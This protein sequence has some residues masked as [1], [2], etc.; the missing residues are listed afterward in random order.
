M[1]SNSKIIEDIHLID[2][3]ILGGDYE[4]DLESAGGVEYSLPTGEELEFSK[5]S[6]V[7]IIIPKRPLLDPRYP[8]MSPRNLSRMEEYALKNQAYKKERGDIIT[9]EE[10]IPE[11]PTS[12]LRKNFRHKLHHLDAVGVYNIKLA[13]YYKK[14]FAKGYEFDDIANFPELDTE[15]TSVKRKEIVGPYIKEDFIPREDYVF[16]EEREKF[17]DRWGRYRVSYDNANMGSR[18]AKLLKSSEQEDKFNAY[19]ASI[20]VNLDADDPYGYQ[21]GK[22]GSG[23]ITRTK[24]RDLYYEEFYR[25]RLAKNSFLTEEDYLEQR[26]EEIKKI[27]NKAEEVFQQEIAAADCRRIELFEEGKRRAQ[28]IKDGH[29]SRDGPSPLI[30]SYEEEATVKAIT[31]IIRLESYNEPGFLKWKNKLV[32]QSP[33]SE[34]VD[35]T[36]DALNSENPGSDYNIGFLEGYDTG[37][38]EIATKIPK[39]L[40]DSIVESSGI[41]S[42][43]TNKDKL[44]ILKGEYIIEKYGKNP[45]GFYTE[46]EKNDTSSK[47]KIMPL[48]HDSWRIL[49]KEDIP[50]KHSQG[51]TTWRA[52]RFFGRVD[53]SK[54]ERMGEEDNPFS[55]ELPLKKKITRIDP[56]R[57]KKWSL[58]KKEKSALIFN[59]KTKRVFFRLTK[60][61][62]N[63]MKKFVRQNLLPVFLK[64]NNFLDCNLRKMSIE[65]INSGID[66]RELLINF[67]KKK[68]STKIHTRR[69]SDPLIRKAYAQTVPHSFKKSNSENAYCQDIKLDLDY[70]LPYLRSPISAPHGELNMKIK[71]ATIVYIKNFK[72]GILCPKTKKKG[73]LLQA[74]VK[75]SRAHDLNVLGITLERVSGISCVRIAHLPIKRKIFSLG[76]SPHA[77][78]KTFEQYERK[79][80]KWQFSIYAVGTK[81]RKRKKIR[82]RYIAPRTAYDIRKILKFCVFKVIPGQISFILNPKRE[83]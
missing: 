75:S 4:R 6:S 29:H 43:I 60:T 12:P 67:Q 7:D 37:F 48:I 38:Q 45:Y 23:P 78:G 26:V 44:F 25:R 22:D 16:P 58:I 21:K 46:P 71:P 27:E 81:E 65:S 18:R 49:Q 47:L 54:P 9:N 42:R 76:R 68:S 53:K 79:T 20:G 30:L 57:L 69:H 55:P 31:R 39:E 80:H 82:V 5:N 33:F 13:D 70:G 15:F 51:C 14:I 56:R 17:K 61:I 3:Y 52:Y 73:N 72:K 1:A 2:E 74:I 28:N 50:H 24:A 11:K 8:L 40:I 34:S 77:Q 66:P 62:E 64:T 35:P 32:P 63:C 59:P 83:K 19:Y 10:Y 36:F 41:P